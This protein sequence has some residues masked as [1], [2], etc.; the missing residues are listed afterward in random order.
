MTSSLVR[1]LRLLLSVVVGPRGG[2]RRGSDV[3]EIMVMAVAV[4]LAPLAPVIGVVA[5]QLAFAVSAADAAEQAARR[6]H[7]TA[8]LGEDAPPP[9]VTT[10]SGLVTGS[11]VQASWLAPD[12]TVHTGRVMAV[13][14]MRAGQQ[15]PLWTDSS[16]APV[17]APDSPEQLRAGAAFVGTMAGLGWLVLLAAAVAGVRWT[18]DRHRL[19]AWQRQWSAVE[20]CW[21]R[22][23]L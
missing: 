5:G 18:L 14:G 13:T 10:F 8:V 15:L 2:L 23:L 4:V 21:R 20:A 9:V 1:P 22:E 17:T 3:I 16:G 19:C 7:T 12:S 11:L 6:F